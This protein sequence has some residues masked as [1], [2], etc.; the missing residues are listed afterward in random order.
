MPDK[1]K[2]IHNWWTNL[3]IEI[4]CM[5]GEYIQNCGMDEDG[6]PYYVI[7][8]NCGQKW[9]ANLIINPIEDFDESLES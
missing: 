9:Q 1:S 2:Q 4:H 3:D 5:C 6:T 8:P 7:C